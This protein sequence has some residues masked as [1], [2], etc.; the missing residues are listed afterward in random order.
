[1]RLF[2]NDI[3]LQ[4]RMHILQKMDYYNLRS[5]LTKYGVRQSPRFLLENI[6]LLLFQNSHGDAL[7]CRHNLEIKFSHTRY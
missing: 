3:D 2:Q 4:Q 1:M 7:F 5:C 6:A